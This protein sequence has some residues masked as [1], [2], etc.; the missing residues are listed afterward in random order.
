MESSNNTHQVSQDNVRVKS[1]V[2]IYFFCL[3]I[4]TQKIE[5]VI[6]LE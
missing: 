5:V 1:I 2:T 4:L 6:Q 3:F